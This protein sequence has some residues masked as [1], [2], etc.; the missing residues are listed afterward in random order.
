MKQFAPLQSSQHL[1]HLQYRPDIDGL[2]ALAVLSVVGFHFF[3]GRIKGGFV[4]VDI[5]FVISGFL[6]SSIIFKSFETNHFRYKEFY[7]R[8]IRRIFPALMLV[9]LACAVLGW[10]V[11]AGDEY[12]QLG[13]HIIAG[14]AFVSNFALWGEAGYFDRAIDNKPLMHL[15]SLGIE[16]QFYVV[17]PLLVGL[18][19]KRKWNL[20]TITVSTAVVSFVINIFT[21]KHNAIEAFYSPLSRF[22]ELML[23]GVLARASLRDGYSLLEN[24]NLRSTVGVLLI[25]LSVLLLGGAQAFPGWWALP[26]TVGAVLVI[27]A[28]PSAWLNKRLLANKVLVWV[29][30]ISYPLYLWHWL[31]ISFACIIGF[32]ARRQIF[33][34]GIASRLTRIF[35]ILLSILLAWLTYRVM[36]KPI[37]QKKGA[38]SVIVLSVLM[39]MLFALGLFA[40]SNVLLP[41]HQNAALGKITAAAKSWEYPDGLALLDSHGQTFYV[42]RSSGNESVLFFGDSHFHQ[43][44]P[45]VIELSKK[46]NFKSKSVYFAALEGCPPIP[47]VFEAKRQGCDEFRNEAIQFAL[48]KHVDTVVIGAFWN[49]YFIRDTKGTRGEGKGLDYYV[50]QNRE[51]VWF[52]GGNGRTLALASLEALLKA[53]SACKTVYLLLDNPLGAAFAPMSYVQGSRLEKLSVAEMPRSVQYAEEQKA[54]REE[55]RDIA[56]RSGAQV[57]DPTETLCPG[58]NCAVTTSDGEPIYRDE[59]HLRPSYVKRY[60]DYIDIAIKSGWEVQ[61]QSKSCPG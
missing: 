14:S 13:K 46:S 36:E 52:R 60:A 18:A 5:F 31:L 35:L 54:L 3:P 9:L 45:R 10:Y 12:A 39:V 34:S 55:L 47:Y 25:V 59:D 29:G 19:W 15:W 6:I 53:V 4:G 37:R 44:S 56:T 11:M 58:D 21:I 41:R 16:E 57:I 42:S 2:R 1:V 48:S 26:P 17:W 43:Y 7:A 50:L 24:S 33:D 51:K 40:Q 32:G 22:W 20:L 38:V 8:R 23:G 27:S 28:G 61:R 30:L 49:G